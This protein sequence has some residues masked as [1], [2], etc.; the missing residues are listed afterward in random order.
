MFDGCT[1]LTTAPELPATTLAYF[2]YSYMFNGCK[3]LNY[4]KCLALDIS[5]TSCVFEWLNDVA[6]SGTFVK[7]SAM[8]D[9]TSGNSGIPLNWSVG[10]AD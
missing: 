4:V 5:A 10:N 3:K 2:S 6:P 9:W 7:A 1:D 8:K